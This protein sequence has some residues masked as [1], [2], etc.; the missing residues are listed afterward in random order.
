MGQTKVQRAIKQCGVATTQKRTPIATD[1]FVPNHSG[2]HSAGRVQRTPSNDDDIVN[3]AYVDINDPVHWHSKLSTSDG[4]VD[5]II[6]VG[7]TGIVS[8]SSALICSSVLF[9]R[10]P[11]LPSIT[12]PAGTVA[13]QSPAFIVPIFTITGRSY[14]ENN[15]CPFDSSMSFFS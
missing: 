15:C 4:D 9:G 1:M 14:I 12:A 7:A 3:K 10:N 5:P 6:T 13:G 2:D 11:I 8:L